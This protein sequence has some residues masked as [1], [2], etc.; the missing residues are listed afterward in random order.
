MI[1]DILL[2]LKFKIL[3][4]FNI[5]Y[6]QTPLFEQCKLALFMP[7]FYY[8]GGFPQPQLITQNILRIPPKYHIIFLKKRAKPIQTLYV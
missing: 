2:A 3:K 8:W 1:F 6:F 4:Y 5:L 7:L